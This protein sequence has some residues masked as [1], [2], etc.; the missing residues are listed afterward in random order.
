MKDKKQ[1]KEIQGKLLEMAIFIDEICKKNNIEYYLAYDTCL[2][3]IRHNGFI[4]WD[5]DYDIVMTY[6]NYQKFIKVMELQKS[7]YVIQTIYND[8]E[9]NRQFAKVRNLETTYIECGNENRN[10]IQGLYIDVFPLVGYPNGKIKQL[11]FKINRALAMYPYSNM[12]NNKF[13][14]ILVKIIYLRTNS[15]KISHFYEKKIVKYDTQKTDLWMSVFG[16]DY[17]KNILNKEIYGKPIL[18]DFNGHKFPVPQKSHEYLTI[19][20]GDYMKIPSKEKIESMQH[21][22]YKMDL[23]KSYKDYIK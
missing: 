4:P 19:T 10:M 6:D 3:A 22:V 20:Y 11:I 5:D 12:I 17:E 2:G 23:N 18:A 1:L 13:M 14:N 15:K 16:D 21:H 8:P 9:Y 7:K